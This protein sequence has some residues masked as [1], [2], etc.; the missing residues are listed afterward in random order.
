MGL[1]ECRQLADR[2]VDLV[3]LRIVGIVEESNIDFDR[4]GGFDREYLDLP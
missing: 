2:S 4:R 3:R 1:V